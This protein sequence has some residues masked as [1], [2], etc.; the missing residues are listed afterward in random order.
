MNGKCLQEQLCPLGETCVPLGVPLARKFGCATLLCPNGYTFNKLV[1]VC[2]AV[3]ENRVAFYKFDT[4]YL[5][6]DCVS[7]KA[8]V[9]RTLYRFVKEMAQRDY[10]DILK[11]AP[12]S[13]VHWLQSSCSLDSGGL[14]SGV[15]KSHFRISHSG[16]MHTSLFKLELVKPIKVRRNFLIATNFTYSH[17]THLYYLHVFVN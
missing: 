14:R 1:D 7:S 9:N 11:N 13:W 17:Y 6:F 8:A 5:P 10:N 2:L 16:D 12:R 15:D 3:D 4:L